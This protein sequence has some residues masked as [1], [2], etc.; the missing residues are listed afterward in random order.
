[1]VL[2]IHF[3]SIKCKGETT[4]HSNS[5]DASDHSGY[6]KTNHFKNLLNVFYTICI[7]SNY[8]V[9]INYVTDDK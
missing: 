5:S 9:H 8:I 2:G 6:M 7:Y 4:F 3:R 1:M